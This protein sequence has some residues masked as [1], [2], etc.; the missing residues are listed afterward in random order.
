[1]E[2][3]FDFAIVGGGIIGASFAYHLLSKGY[4]VA[5]FDREN[6]PDQ[7]SVR[8]FGQ[9]VPSGFGKEWQK[10]GITS[11]EIYR[12]IQ[13]Q[14]QL[15]LKEEGSLYIASDD[16]EIRLL[17]ELNF[18]NANN[19]Y[20]SILLDHSDIKK[21]YPEIRLSYARA[22][23]QF[24]L[25]IQINPKTTVAKILLWLRETKK[26]SYYN[27]LTIQDIEVSNNTIHLTD[28]FKNE[29]LAKKVFICSGHDF[30]TLLPEIFINAGLITVK[31]QML[32]GVAKGTKLNGSILTG[33][34]IRRYESFVECPSFAQIKQREDATSFQRKHGVHILAKQELDG[35][36]IL[37]DS[38]H[39]FPH[40]QQGI[41]TE[42]QDSS[43]INEFI[44][45][46]AKKILNI[47]H[48]IIKNSWSGYYSQC[49]DKPVFVN[50]I[51]DGITVVTGIGGKGM[52]AAFGYTHD[53]LN[54][55][56][57]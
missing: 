3:E 50:H 57:I 4:S 27:N 19:N 10:H 14:A 45:W 51:C 11:M 13:K 38:H 20:D 24:P 23:L 47:D 30:K 9:I 32:S 41:Q 54:N 17:E 22:G 1:M 43:Q 5:V 28:N 49:S 21:L 53:F 52:T 39:Y 37:G 48:F 55:L 31:L 26:L 33:W 8:N 7:A 46:E 44:L 12:S 34:S 35:T 16:D 40:D 36:I 56:N 6:S 18:I 15:D 2:T 29:Y 25:E 42:Y